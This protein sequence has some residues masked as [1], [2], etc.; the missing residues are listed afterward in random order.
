MNKNTY[1]VPCNC[2]NRV[3]IDKIVS[4]LIRTTQGTTTLSWKRVKHAKNRVTIE[5][6]EKM[7]TACQI[8][9]RHSNRVTILNFSSSQIVRQFTTSI[10]GTRQFTTSIFGTGLDMGSGW[11]PISLLPVHYPCFKIE[12]NSI[13]Y[14]NLV[15]M[16]RPRQIGFDSGGYPWVWV[17]LSCLL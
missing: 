2:Q 11:I 1:I 10:F 7:L 9:T 12:E 14:P 4:R 6:P 3:T 5:H 16:G 13:T 17:L 8:L 15:K